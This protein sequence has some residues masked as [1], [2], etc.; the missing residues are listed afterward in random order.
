MYATTK[1]EKGILYQVVHRF[2]QNISIF[3]CTHYYDDV[4][5]RLYSELEDMLRLF[6][7]PGVSAKQVLEHALGLSTDPIPLLGSS[8]ENKNYDTSR[9]GRMRLEFLW[10]ARSLAANILRIIFCEPAT[11]A[12][13]SNPMVLENLEFLCSS[14]NGEN[15]WGAFQFEFDQST[16]YRKAVEMYRVNGDDDKRVKVT[17]EGVGAA[18]STMHLE[19]SKCLV[20]NLVQAFRHRGHVY[21]TQVVNTRQSRRR[22]CATLVSNRFAQWFHKFSEKMPRQITIHARRIKT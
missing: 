20:L 2:P 8:F 15:L 3:I 7:A 17:I 1:T 19:F 13:N 5:E 9:P 4:H 11:V 12:T 10:K 14:C 6:G 18:P 16:A 22:V 21:E